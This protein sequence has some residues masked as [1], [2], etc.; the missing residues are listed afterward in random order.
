VS[1]AAARGTATGEA[2]R[3]DEHP[4]VLFDGVCGLCQGVVRFVLPRDRAGRFRFAP[5]QSELGRTLLA[6][7]RLDPDALD[8]FVVVDA[9]GA[10]TRSEAALRLAAGLG[11]P[12]SALGV[13]RALPRP[14]RDALYDVVARHRYRWFGRLDACP[15]PSP[16]WRERFLA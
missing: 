6:R 9:A 15:A 7:H 8:T 1:P 5:L 11:A 16:A 4:V 2:A 3:P 12:W 13:L 14:L 10:H